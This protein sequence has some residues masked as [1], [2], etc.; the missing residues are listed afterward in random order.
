[1]TISWQYYEIY[2]K[3]CLKK[4]VSVALCIV[5]VTFVLITIKHIAV[6]INVVS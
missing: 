6:D 1:M 3:M 2:G 4:A 5:N